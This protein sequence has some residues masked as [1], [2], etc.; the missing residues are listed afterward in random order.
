VVAVDLRATVSPLYY[1]PDGVPGA[2]VAPLEGELVEGKP[3][4]V[5]E[6]VEGIPGAP[7]GLVVGMPGGPGGLVVGI[8]GG[9]GGLVVGI[10][11]AAGVV[12]APLTWAKTCKPA[13]KTIRKSTTIKPILR[14][15]SKN[16]LRT[17]NAMGILSLLATL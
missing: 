4:A 5:G 2:F 13:P 16:S 17:R 11:G 3:G 8:P 12:G 15:I 9:P 1:A 14:L 6:L 10:P 7:G